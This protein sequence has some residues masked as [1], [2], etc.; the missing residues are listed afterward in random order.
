[1][2]VDAE[3]E[4]AKS[5]PAWL[6]SLYRVPSRSYRALKLKRYD[7][8]NLESLSQD[9][10][11]ATVLIGNPE[12][13][14]PV[15]EMGVGRALTLFGYAVLPSTIRI[16]W[17]AYPIDRTAYASGHTW[18]G[19][20][21]EQSRLAENEWL[22]PTTKRIAGFARLGSN[23][24]G[25]GA[26]QPHWGTCMRALSAAMKMAEISSMSSVSSSEPPYVA[27]LSSGGI[28]FEIRNAN[29]ELNLA[30]E[31]G[32]KGVVE[33]LKTSTTPAQDEIEEEFEFEESRLAEVLTWV[34]QQS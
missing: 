3:N 20:Q 18:T 12:W 15:L 13:L 16:Y 7:E 23:W 9:N 31:P 1:M 17:T 24:D 30:F 8:R 2:F 21:T 25:Y 33:V 34:F 19:L 4:S 29:R 28:L 6:A 5:S 26:R 22:E 32:K 14:A 27:P 11:T 10:S